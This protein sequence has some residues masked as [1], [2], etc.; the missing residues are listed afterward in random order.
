[1]NDPRAIPP[2]VRWTLPIT[3]TTNAMA[4]ALF[5]CLRNAG[6][7]QISAA[8]FERAASGRHRALSAGTLAD[9]DGRV[10]PE[11]VQVMREV[12]IDV[13]DRRPQ[14]LTHGAGREPA[15]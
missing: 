1:M 13:S 7:S 12:G 14:K 6:R 11:V 9:P 4:T 10:H 15:G 5:V 3:S 2:P 8:L